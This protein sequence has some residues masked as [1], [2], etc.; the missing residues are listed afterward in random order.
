MKYALSVKTFVGKFFFPLSTRDII[1]FAL[2]RRSSFWLRDA[3]STFPHFSISAQTIIVT[4]FFDTPPS[5]FS[6]AAVSISTDV[7][8]IFHFIFFFSNTSSGGTMPLFFPFHASS[9]TITVQFAFVFHSNPNQS[10]CFP[11]SCNDAV[12]HEP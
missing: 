8:E 10:Q 3:T 7:V 12:W 4:I 9:T 1:Y 6:Q 5:P 11:P 2:S